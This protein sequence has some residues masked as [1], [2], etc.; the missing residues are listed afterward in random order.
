MIYLESFQPYTEDRHVYPYRTIYPM[1]L[2]HIEF[3]PITI[4]YGNNGSGKSTLLNVIANRIGIRN[5]TPGN[6]NEYFNSY[7]QKC[8]FRSAKPLPEDCAFIRSEDIMEQI[9]VNRKAYDRAIS[10]FKKSSSMDDSDG[11]GSLLAKMFS[12]PD[13]VSNSER[14]FMSRSSYLSSVVTGIWDIGEKQMSNGE[15]A[16]DYFRSHLFTDTLY[17]LDEPENSMAPAYQAELAK[18][19][20]ILAYRL[21]TQFIIATHSPFLLSIQGARIYDLDSHPST[22]KEWF[23]LENMK[24]YFELFYH[25]R[26]KFGINV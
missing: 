12:D 15:K 9:A 26:K 22:Q 1:G 13:D 11:E 24:S 20:A 23:Q 8:G 14:F 7:V 3:A 2:E 5:M 6:S 18:M 17:L 10:G 25:S 16:M 21:N 4:L 19:I